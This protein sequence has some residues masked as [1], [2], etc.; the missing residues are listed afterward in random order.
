MTVCKTKLRLSPELS[1]GSLE[2]GGR[3]RGFG[4]MTGIKLWFC[5]SAGGGPWALKLLQ[6]FCASVSSCLKWGCKENL[7]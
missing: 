3:G 5:Q 4:A 7:F 1:L 6:S 2:W